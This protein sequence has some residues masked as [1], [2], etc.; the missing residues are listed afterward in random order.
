MTDYKK[1]NLRTPAAPH[2]HAPED[3]RSIMLDVIIAL[4]PALVWAV[5]E[6]GFRALTV[7]CFSAAGCVFWEWLYRRVRKK[8]Q[9]A[10][11][12]S[13]AVTGILLAF[14]CPVTVGY[15]QILIGDFFAVVVVKQLFG[16]I[17]RNLVNP[18]LAGRAVMLLFWTSSMTAWADPLKFR[19][20]VLG[21]N[22]DII[23]S[24]VPMSYL[25]QNNLE[26]LKKAGITMLDLFRGSYG[27]SLGEVSALMLLLGGAYLLI[28]RVIQWEI[29]ICYIG[30]VALLAL[31]F[32][33]GNPPAEWML[34]NVLSGG[35]ILGAVFMATDCSTSPVTG[36]GRVVY[37]VG[38]GLLATIFRRLGA[39]NGGVYY[40]I[41][42]M[43]C[44]VPLID[45]VAR[46]ARFGTGKSVRRKKSSAE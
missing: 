25:H 39:Y 30:T 4:C 13:A 6:F 15:W 16:G 40:A 44:C 37:A 33:R 34:Y 46:P 23:P 12:L 41:L 31:I 10:A 35:L 32:P 43:N 21:P 11:D 14:V 38:C 1:L 5:I 42:V 29:P 18:A 24:A 7:T 27:G 26:A 19:A 2:I 8:P 9:S 36:R 28:R 20:T 3:T 22:T 45:R 17:G